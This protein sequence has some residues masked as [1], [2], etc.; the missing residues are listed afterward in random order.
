MGNSFR[1]LLRAL[2]SHLRDNLRFARF[3]AS[4]ISLERLLRVQLDVV[5]EEQ[6]RAVFG[7]VIPPAPIAVGGRHVQLSS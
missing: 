5:G 6:I 7:N 1:S 2:K 4:G 3:D